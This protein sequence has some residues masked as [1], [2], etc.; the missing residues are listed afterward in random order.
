MRKL[1]RS[2]SNKFIAGV[3]GGIAD[4]LNMDPN[5]VRII[6]VVIGVLFN[7]ATI[8]AYIIAWLILPTDDTG[9]YGAEKVKGW[10]D[11]RRNN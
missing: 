6:V 4:Y 7:V 9:E 11:E 1:T 3:C 5:V 2:S 8:T 10:I